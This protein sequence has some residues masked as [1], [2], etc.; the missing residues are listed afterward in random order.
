MVT[1]MSLAWRAFTVKGALKSVLNAPFP[2]LRPVMVMSAWPSLRTVTE[3]WACAVRNTSPKSTDAVSWP[4]AGFRS[5][6]MVAVKGTSTAG[7]TRSFELMTRLVRVSPAFICSLARTV[8]RT[9]T[10]SPG[11]SRP[12]VGAMVSIMLGAGAAMRTAVPAVKAM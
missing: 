3:R 8:A 6:V 10:D 5:P 11:A 7:L 1:T 9:V 2:K 12:S 4:R